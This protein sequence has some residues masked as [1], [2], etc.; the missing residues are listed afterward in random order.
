MKL[1]ATI[2]CYNEENNIK[3]CLE[4]VKDLVDEIIVVDSFSTDQTPK[5]CKSYSKVKFFDKKFID[6]GSQKQYAVEQTNNDWVLSLDADEYLSDEL[7]SKI[8][9]I[10]F[11][12][13]KLAYNILRLNYYCG[14]WIKYSGWQSDFQLRLWNKKHGIWQ[15][16]IHERVE[17]NRDIKVIKIKEY[18]MHKSIDNFSEHMKIIDKY[19]DMGAEKS[20]KRSKK[21]SIVKAITHGMFKFIKMYFIK[22]GFL[23][24]KMG[25]ILALNSSFYVYLKY[26]KLWQLNKN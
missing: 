24:G 23:D 13:E 3:D 16:N 7:K 2:I 6:F 9:S 21:S 10:D 15:G 1:S 14:K 22:L 26:I 19:T 25:F 4:S 20:F 18:M 11:E 12:N 5:I 8:Q 17:V